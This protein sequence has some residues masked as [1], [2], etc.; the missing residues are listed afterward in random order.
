MNYEQT[1]VEALAAWDAGRTVWTIEMGGLGP[2]YEQ[3]IQTTVFEILRDALAEEKTRATGLTWEEFK[4]LRDKTIH[5]HDDALGGL[6]GAQAG[7]ATSLAWRA[8]QDGWGTMLKKAKD[9][10]IE[11]D[12]FIMVSNF[13]PKAAKP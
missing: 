8:Y 12:R 11:D 9:Q 6:T 1:A 4:V 5:K 3:A 2:G 10:G 7:V 13:T